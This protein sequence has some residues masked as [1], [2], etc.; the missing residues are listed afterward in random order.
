MKFVTI[1]FEEAYLRSAETSRGREHQT[2]RHDTAGFKVTL[3]E[4]PFKAKNFLLHPKLNFLSNF[5]QQFCHKVLL[6]Q[7]LNCKKKIISVD[8]FLW[9]NGSEEKHKRT[10][11]IKLKMARTNAR[12]LVAFDEVNALFLHIAKQHIQRRTRP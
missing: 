4:A 1:F 3:H 8:F 9:S 10:Q 2:I 12:N 6:I 7:N 5:L 11:I